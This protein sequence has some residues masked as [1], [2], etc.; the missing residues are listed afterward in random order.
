MTAT[1]LLNIAEDAPT[2]TNSQYVYIGSQDHYTPPNNLPKLSC[3]C[4]CVAESGAGRNQQTE[5]VAS[6]SLYYEED[7]S[8]TWQ[9]SSNSSEQGVLIITGLFSNIV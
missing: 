9:S 7:N 8:V 5:L 2:A 3:D 6:P 4:T 1:Y